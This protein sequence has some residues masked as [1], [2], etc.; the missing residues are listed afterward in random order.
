MIDRGPDA[1]EL[2][3]HPLH[4]GDQRVD[5]GIVIGCEQA[6]EFRALFSDDLLNRGQDMLRRNL[7]EA[8]QARRI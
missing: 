2:M 5:A 8:R 4:G 3:L 6:V 7:I 1:T